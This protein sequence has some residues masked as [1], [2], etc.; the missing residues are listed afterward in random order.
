MAGF[1]FEAI[2]GTLEGPEL[3]K[4]AEVERINVLL[5]L[6]LGVA[7]RNNLSRSNVFETDSDGFWT[8]LVESFK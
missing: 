8:I 5:L 4:R 7:R 2:S 3:I 6:M 1:L